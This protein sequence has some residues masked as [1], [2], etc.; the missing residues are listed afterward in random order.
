VSLDG[1]HWQGN[2]LH[3]NTTN[4][5]IDLRVPQHYN[6]HLET[7]TVNGGIS[8]DFPV[9][10]QGTIKNHLNTDLGSGGS[11]VHIQTVNGGIN[12]SHN[13]TASAD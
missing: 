2:G 7:A 13:Q 1:D 5:G 10:V 3:A 8:I 11:T 6:A 12:I 9:T 4:G